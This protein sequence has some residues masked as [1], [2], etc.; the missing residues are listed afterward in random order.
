MTPG[1]FIVWCVCSGGVT[2]HREGPLKQD[3]APIVFDTREAAED[4][5]RGLN[6]SHAERA[7]MG[8]AV[9]DLRY[10]ARPV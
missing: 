2:G 4:R 5:A 6:Q 7:S 9:A 1:K 3:G 10:W 8:Q